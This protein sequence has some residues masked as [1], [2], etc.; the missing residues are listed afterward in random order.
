MVAIAASKQHEVA[1]QGLSGPSN[2]D[3]YVF[4]HAHDFWTG[5]IPLGSTPP[6]AQ[7]P[8]PSVL[9]LFLSVDRNNYTYI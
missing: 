4:S 8:K 5:S 6:V 7:W 2:V 9:P 1:V 3:T